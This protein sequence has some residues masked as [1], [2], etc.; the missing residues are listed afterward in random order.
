MHYKLSPLIFVLLTISVNAQS[1]SWPYDHKSLLKELK[2]T[3]SQLEIKHGFCQ[4]LRKREITQIENNWLYAQPKKKQELILHVVSSIVYERCTEAEEAQ[5]TMALMNYTSE[6]GDKT[7]LNE[8]LLLN[9][10]Y[11]TKEM[12]DE[13]ADIDPAD[14]LKLAELPVLYYP[15]KLLLGVDITITKENN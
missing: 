12:F 14:I 5:Y 3:Y 2:S 4:D 10:S 6:T 13:L 7:F 11:Y 15:F 8:W 1:L 9:K